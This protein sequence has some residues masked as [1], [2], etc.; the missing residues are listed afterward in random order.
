MKK[1][2][3][4][5]ALAATVVCSCSQ[6]EELSII[7][8]PDGNENTIG[9]NSLT[10]S[11]DGSTRT[12]ST[13]GITTNW[14]AG[15]R[16]YIYDNSSA[17]E[18]S[19][20]Q[21]GHPTAIFTGTANFKNLT[22]AVYGHTTN[23]TITSNGTVTEISIPESWTYNPTKNC[24]NCIMMGLVNTTN[25]TVAFKNAGAILYV[26]LG[27]EITWNSTTKLVVT[28]GN[29]AISGPATVTWGS[30]N[31]PTYTCTS[32]D[33]ANKTIEITGPSSSE[34]AAA[35]N[36][37]IPM[38][39]FSNTDVITV[40]LVTTPAEGEST[41]KLIFSESA[42]L[43]RNEYYRI[44]YIKENVQTVFSEA[45]LTAAITAGNKAVIGKDITLG[46]YSLPQIPTAGSTEETPVY[47]DLHA[48]IDLNGHK[49]TANKITTNGNSLSITGETTGILTA[50]NR[51]TEI[52]SDANLTLTNVNLTGHITSTGGN[53]RLTG[54]KI[55][56]SNE[57]GIK[58]TAE[59][60]PTV[61]GTAP[62][63]TITNCDITANKTAVY[64]KYTDLEITGST[65]TVS[66]EQTSNDDDDGT[67]SGYCIAVIGGGDV[68]QAPAKGS[69][70]L[71]ATGSKN[72]Y[73]IANG[74]AEKKNVYIF[75]NE[76][77]H[78]DSGLTLD[79]TTDQ[80]K[81]AWKVPHKDNQDNK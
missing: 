74:D 21:G 6:N 70:T 24:A 66:A 23:P 15:D 14:V 57:Y 13:D 4:I 30:D 77:S 51:E 62:K 37:I 59:S 19:T 68:E 72:T 41:E 73:H 75:A 61:V 60:Y 49:L 40:K 47:K 22:Y 17:V 67:G 29:T 69:I 39:V 27:S 31:Y 34:D 36:I 71:G 45:G 16:I 8:T 18:F 38:P 78:S 53:N 54:V 33:E 52:V 35:R 48:Q 55:N 7:E 58:A 11:F 32:T 65:L 43:K 20:T 25:Y 44:D 56:S 3:Y 42:K 63:F 50:E 46:E 10:A 80:A 9:Q 81:I 64:L 5:L 28:T 2:Y 12:M 26:T 79:N 76:D 1:V